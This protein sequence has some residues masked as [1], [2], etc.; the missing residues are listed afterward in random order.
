MKPDPHRL[1]SVA[2]L[3]TALAPLVAQ[4]LSVLPTLIVT[5]LA[6][7]LDGPSDAQ[8]EYDA[9]KRVTESGDLPTLRNVAIR[10]ATLPRFVDDIATILREVLPHACRS[11]IAARRLKL[12]TAPTCSA[13]PAIYRG[14]AVAHTAHVLALNDENIDAIRARLVELLDIEFPRAVEQRGIAPEHLALSVTPEAR[15]SAAR[16]WTEHERHQNE[17]HDA[18][19]LRRA[20]IEDIRLGPNGPTALKR[21]GQRELAAALAKVTQRAKAK[22]ARVFS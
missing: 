21:A 22:G 15:A 7:Q 1:V 9:C 16:E 19:A 11:H 14:N 8:I 5:E 12:A 17:I 10:R 18:H 2:E 3:R 6:R 20:H 13:V 4:A